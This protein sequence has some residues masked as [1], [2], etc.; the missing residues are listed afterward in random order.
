MNKE[1]FIKELESVTGLDNNKCTIINN[2]LEDYFIIGKNNKEKIIND[3]MAQLQITNEK[4]EKIYE[5]AMSII[6]TR[7][8]DKL[9]HPF[10][11]QDS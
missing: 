9:R 10:K 2:I 6:G 4:A 3:I 5:S 1:K 7:I 8:K 11:N